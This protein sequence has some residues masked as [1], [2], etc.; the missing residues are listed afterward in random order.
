MK[1]DKDRRSYSEAHQTHEDCGYGYKVACCYRERYSKPIQTYRDENA[2]YKFMEK[3][4]KEVEYCKAVIKKH[5][6]KPLVMTEDDEQ[7]LELW[8]GVTF[9]V[10]ST[11]TKM[12]ALETIA[13]SLENTEAKLTKNV[14]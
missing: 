11:L 3:M 4:L 7:C 13:T 12:C 2:V 6:N 8:M 14:T 9:V 10:K 5:F 1:K